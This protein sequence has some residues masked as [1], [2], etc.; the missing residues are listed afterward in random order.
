MLVQSQTVAPD[1]LLHTVRRVVGGTLTATHSQTRD[2]G[3]V[4][5]SAH[6]VNKASMLR[7]GL[8]PAGH[9]RAPTLPPSGTCPM[10]STCS[11]GWGCRTSWPTPIP[12]CWRWTSRWCRGNAESGVGRTILGW[13]EPG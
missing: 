9:R 6:G 4:E 7:A 2:F 1:D 3:L 8:R 5:I 10:M 11:A 12:R 13:L